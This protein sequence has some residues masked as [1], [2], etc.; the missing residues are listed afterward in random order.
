[1][2]SRKQAPDTRQKTSTENAQP[3]SAPANNS[4]LP[5]ISLP[6]GGGAMRGMGEKFTA[7]PVLGSGSLALPLPI[8]PGRSGFEP[9]LTLSYDSN[10]GNGPFGM[11]WSLSL[12]ALTRKTLK[13]LPRYVDGEESDTF[14]LSSAEDLVPLLSEQNGQWTRDRSTCELYGQQYSVQRYRPRIEGAFAR[15]ERW[16]NVANPQDTFW[17]TIS[18]DNVTSWYG[19]SAESR[20]ADPID[21]GRVFSWLLCETYDDKGNVCVY[22]YK[23]EN[24]DNVDA[25]QAN[26]RNRAPLTRSAN[27]YLKRARYGNRTPYFPNLA[28]SSP[29][30]LPNDWL[31]ELVFD[32][33]EH[34]AQAP[35][36]QETGQFWTCRADAF[37]TY[38]ATFE[39]RTYRLCQRVLMFHHFAHEP[40]VGLNCLVRSLDLAYTQPSSDPTKPFYAF[41]LSATQK[42]YIRQPGGSSYL[43]SALPPLTLAYSEAVIDETVQQIDPTS[44]ENLPYGLDG[45]NYQWVDLDG[46]GTPGILS[47]Q[48]GSWFYKS[49][50]S[51]ANLHMN[52]GAPSTPAQFGP[53]ELVAH[54]AS[55]STLN[56]QNQALLDLDGNGQLDLVAFDGPTPGF[57]ERT[58]GNE[59]STP[60]TQES[61]ADKTWTPF[62]TFAELP[63]LDWQDPNLRLVD[64]TGDGLADVLI[65]EDEALCWHASLGTEGFAPAQRVRQELDEERGPKLI[66]ADSTFSIFL[67]D[68]SGDGLLDLARIRNGEVCYWPNL[69]YGTFGAKVTMDQAPW[70]ESSDIFDGRRVRLADI[71]GSGTTDI[72]YFASSGVQ[73]VFNQSGNAWGRPRTLSTFPAVESVSSASVLDLLGSGTAC[74]VWSSALERYADVPMRYIDLMGG[75]KP[76]LLTQVTNNLGA[77][78]VIQYAPSTSF[79]V[80]DKLAG[81]PWVTRIP[82]PVQVVAQVEMRDLV[83]RSRFV[84]RYNYHHGFYDGF[85][86]EFRGFGRVEQIDGEAFEDYVVGVTQNNGTQDLTPELFQPPVTTITWFHTGALLEPVLVQHYLQ[87]E[88][89]GQAQFLSAPAF[90]GGLDDEEWRECARALKGLPLRQEVYSFDGSSQAHIPYSVTEHTYNVQLVQKRAGEQYAVFLPTGSETFARALERNPADPRTV[91]SLTLEVDQYGQV[92]KAASV[93]YG[94]KIADPTLPG[95]VTGEQQKLWITYAE[96][97]YTPDLDQG[98]PTTTYRLRVPYATRAYEVTGVAPASGLF[99]LADLHSQVASATDIPYEATA[100]GTTPQRRLLST[101]QTLFRDNALNPLP[102]GQWDTLALPY[103]S[104]R[105]AFTPGVIGTYYGGKLADGDFTAAGYVHFNGDANW[106]IPSGT[107]VYPANPASHFYLP[108]GAIDALGLETDITFDAYDLLPTQTQSKQA[109]WN[110]VSATNDYRVLGPV[111]VTDPNQNRTAVEID[112]LGMVVKT[113]VMGKVS[114]NEGDTLAD[115]TTRM[116]YNF[117]NW[118]NN[119]QPNYIHTFAREQHGTG[120][121]RWQ[122]SYV[123]SNGSGGV[124]MVKAQAHPGPALQVN[125]D[126]TTT[127]VNA[128]PRWVGNGR[129][130]L[131]NKGNPVKQ[132]EPYFSTTFAYEDEKALSE[133]GVTPILYYDAVGRLIRTAFPDG[134][135]T[136]VEFDP[137]LQRV[138]DAN[139]TVKESQWYADRGSPDPT[140]QPEPT[141]DPERRAAWLAAKHADTPAVLHFD[142]LG[143]PIYAVSD[144]GSGKTAAV[145]TTSDLTGRTS[146]IYDQLGRQVASGFM[147][148]AGTKIVSS[149]AEKG[150]RWMLPDVLGNLVKTWDEH[151]R[152]FRAGY[153]ELHRAVSTFEQD[154]GQAEIL[155]NYIVYGDRHPNA[156]QLN[157]LGSAHQ[158]FEQS[159]LV[160]VPGLDF[161]GNPTSVQRVLAQDYKHTLDWSSLATQPDYVAIQNAADASLATGEVFTASATYDALNRPT[162]VTLPDQSVIVPTYNEANFLATLQVQVRGQGAFTT[163]LQEQDYDARG[164]RLF[165]HYGNNVTTSYFYDPKTFRLTSLVSAPS[166]GNPA[167][168][169]L[170]N[171]AYTYDPVGNITQLEDTAQQTFY[172]NNA[173]VKP[174]YLYE[175]DA[176]Y[177]LVQA[178]GR[179]HA[180][181]INDTI[182]NASDLAVVP[183]LPEANDSAAVR[184]YTETYTYDLLGNLTAL[185]H[186][187]K[188]QSG[189]GNGWTRAYHYAYQDNPSNATNRLVS[190][191]NPADP[192]GG[193][194]SAAYTYDNYG[195]MAS[196]PSFSSLTWNFVD[197]LQQVNLG[198]GGTAWY[199]YGAGGQRVRKVIERQG[200]LRAERIYLGAVEIYRERQGTSAPNLERYTLHV[201]D[202]VGRIAQVDTKTIDSTNSD[203]ANPLN[204]PLIRYQYGNHLGSA[205]LET[206]AN[207]A[208]IS[209]EEYHPYGTSA[210]RSARP[211]VDLSLKRYRFSGKERDDETG[212]YY[213]GARYYA[214]WLGRWTSSDPAG[215][216]DGLNLF[217]Y[218]RN[219]PVMLRDPHGTDSYEFTDKPANIRKAQTTHTEASG[220]AYEAWVRQHHTISV[221]G[222]TYEVSGGRR[223]W[224]NGSWHIIAVQFREITP[225]DPQ[226]TADTSGSGSSHAGS[227]DPPAKPAPPPIAPPPVPPPSAGGN[228]GSIP[229]AP[230]GTNFADEAARA[231]QAYRAN[232]PMQPGTQVQH[233]TKEISARNTNM[234]PAVMNQNLSPLQSRNRLP[235]T[236]LLTD[237]N[238]GGTT[239]SVDGGSTYGNEH[240]F[241]DR[242]LIPQIEDQIRTANPNANPRD[243]AVQAGR[244][245]RWAMT[246]EPGPDPTPRGAGRL[247]IGLAGVNVGLS[248]YALYRDVKRNDAPMAAGDTLNLAGGG[249]ELYGLATGATIA[250]ASAV[251]VGLVVG[252]AGIA[253]TSGISGY[254]AYQAGDTEGA[255][256]GAVGV[257]AGLAIMAG[258]IFGAPVLLAAG[259]IA[260]LGVGIFHLGRK[261]NWWN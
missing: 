164:Q 5:T 56:H 98:H 50:L 6:K 79:Y 233:W 23:A 85:E 64:L 218:C 168:Q 141:G 185:A 237:P 247:S 35:V 166:G 20:I 25:S 54:Q 130:I 123:Y 113:A 136:R 9:Q 96:T 14:L 66:L 103:Q 60:G 191:S 114:A 221:D 137:W 100:N 124:A 138:F 257:A 68:L 59:N 41:L 195:N 220:R 21:P 43:S 37:S 32:Y 182:L 199:I 155:F 197:Q 125:P 177:Q 162:R 163:F 187:F 47:E 102:S 231:R 19:K 158:V 189:V 120:N 105:M 146:A 67:A 259:L 7:N 202:N 228:G 81:T 248:G 160:Q 42:G 260:A 175:Y 78:T 13:G 174:E 129:T 131:N 144:Y 28:A 62:Q 234:D 169:G 88:Y 82:F 252:G 29:V 132:Y 110:V 242:A 92:L 223:E 80:S 76:H 204:T 108:G 201:A 150:Q 3:G 8:S 200:S 142:N 194:Y 161:Q 17:R 145:R 171:L 180:G 26:E 153:D 207:G 90:P 65:S 156:L 255:I 213:F 249:L 34:D 117:F 38:R 73:V 230:P 157:L 52:N 198:G 44:L 258:V 77:T 112:A 94:R 236:T 127:Q 71:D 256:A 222:H 229:S 238:G 61:T 58:P 186:M 121:P 165:A 254:R 178:S 246:G 188:P 126:G 210:Y 208:V 2:F 116:E 159:G 11:G 149:S 45:S 251:S 16:V 181:P 192:P 224:F 84:T 89:Y 36:P 87:T 95:V 15:I 83:A 40:G 106:W 139:D 193:P 240:K 190:T 212:L 74:L 140:S 183:Q 173:V 115:P 118:M 70:F 214:A 119:S 219:N 225:Q 53:V 216:V 147:G 128:N 91:H 241:A 97:D 75:Q 109:T 203:P 226:K 253:I 86:R 209:Y 4:P 1:M 49:N 10:A 245:A 179:E 31:F 211:G 152:T 167:T 48:G 170:Q 172:F 111:M 154:S 12:P 217:K 232:N 30:T 151:G 72:V 250:G 55:L 22:Q 184:T 27:R 104:Y 261:L 18:R 143:R 239:Y 122:E 215:F 63:L 227:S 148:M 235:A 33:G 176:L 205:T 135:L 107:A 46:E 39:V 206:D 134:T 93:V 51:P 57:F 24:S 196:M 69:G 133:I 244:Q 99:S 243:V 101:R